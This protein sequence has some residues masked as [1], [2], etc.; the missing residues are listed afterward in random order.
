MVLLYFV[1]DRGGR[2]LEYGVPQ[3]FGHGLLDDAVR[4]MIERAQ[5]LPH[6]PETVAGLRL[7]LVVPV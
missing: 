6:P 2:V 4:A 7:E 5:P 1:I 3:S